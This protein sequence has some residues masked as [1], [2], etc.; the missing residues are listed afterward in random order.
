MN[1]EYP[2]LDLRG[3]IRSEAAKKGSRRSLKSKPINGYKTVEFTTRD[4]KKVGPFV[5]KAR[6]EYKGRIINR[7]LKEFTTKSGKHVKFYAPVRDK[8]AFKESLLRRHA[9]AGGSFTSTAR[10]ELGG[11]TAI[12]GKA[13]IQELASSIKR[14]LTRRKKSTTPEIVD[15]G[16]GFG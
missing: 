15:N 11:L 1:Y 12:A 14:K 6:K 8:S 9:Q 3:G 16:I 2:I 13:A 4:G 7:K 10:E 5:A